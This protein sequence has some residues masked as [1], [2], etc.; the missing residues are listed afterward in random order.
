M[1]LTSRTPQAPTP[2][3]ASSAE[4]DATAEA[5][6]ASKARAPK[7]AASRVEAEAGAA[8]IRSVT[9]D[10]IMGSSYPKGPCRP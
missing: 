9:R 10:R 5:A 2:A 4:N 3:K 8:A 7:E 6:E 1:V